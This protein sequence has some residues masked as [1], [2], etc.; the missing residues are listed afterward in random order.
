MTKKYTNKSKLQGKIGTENY[1]VS[2]CPVHLPKENIRFFMAMQDAGNKD[3]FSSDTYHNQITPDWKKS[4]YESIM[5]S[6][7]IEVK[8]ALNENEIKL[9]VDDFDFNNKTQNTSTNGV[10]DVEDVID[11]K[12]KK[13]EFNQLYCDLYNKGLDAMEYYKMCNLS[14]KYGF[15]IKVEDDGNGRSEELQYIIEKIVKE[16][17][18]EVDL[19]W[20]DVSN[21]TDMS[22]LF[23]KSDFNGDIS[24]W[25]V[26]HVKDMSYMFDQSAFNGDFCDLSKWDVS[27]VDYMEGMFRYSPYNRDDIC[28]W[29]VHNLHTTENMFLDSLF[30]QDISKWNLP[31]GCNVHHMFSS[32]FPQSYKPLV[33][34]DIIRKAKEVFDEDIEDTEPFEDERL[35]NGDD[36][37]LDYGYDDADDTDDDT[38]INE[39]FMFEGSWG[40]D[41]NDGD[42][43]LDMRYDIN[44]STFELIYDRCKKTIDSARK[45]KYP[46]WAWDVIG[47]IEYFFDRATSLDNLADE[48]NKNFEK[49]DFWWTL[50]RRKNKDILEL[51]KEA[52]D[53]CE[54]DKKWINDWKEPDKMKKSIK[55]RH[56]ILDKYLK[57]QKQYENNEKRLEKIRKKNEAKSKEEP[58]L[59][60]T[61]VEGFM[62]EGECGECGGVSGSYNTTM[63]TV[64][65]G[66]I[67]PAG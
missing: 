63:N 57:I 40:Y 58:C 44:L 66:N 16:I 51:Y 19:N 28:N 38:E 37:D 7:S 60:E 1:R 43:P 49:Y 67:V 8:K 59:P 4:I 24:D 30:C 62:F 55:R 26:S 14:R 5:K 35:R 36:D 34:K 32:D 23:Q 33:I 15:K 46:S 42:G 22:Y 18:S 13:H 12:V 17:N 25:D 3:P 52:L 64:G 11:I 10:I 53:I 9:A 65:V 27:N 6:V 56:K 50:K 20:I 29:N 45:S 61:I 48:P 2:N 47:Q 21:V 31:L 41:P 39:G 54:K